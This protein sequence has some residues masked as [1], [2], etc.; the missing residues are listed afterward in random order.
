M[1]DFNL[2]EGP[3]CEK[4]K[5]VERFVNKLKDDDVVRGKFN[6]KLDAIKSTRQEEANMVKKAPITNP[7]LEYLEHIYNPP[8][9]DMSCLEIAE[10]DEVTLGGETKRTFDKE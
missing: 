6:K 4:R 9:E 1:E 10:L 7:D 5:R 8:R 2:G 3:L